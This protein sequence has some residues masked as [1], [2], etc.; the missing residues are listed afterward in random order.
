MESTKLAHEISTT[1]VLYAVQ[2]LQED[3]MSL[4]SAQEAATTAHQTHSSQTLTS[5]EMLPV[6]G[7]MCQSIVKATTPTAPRIRLHSA[8]SCAEHQMDF[9]T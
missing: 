6:E 4:S 3:A 2:L 9:V 1:L 5:A 7:V 8:Q